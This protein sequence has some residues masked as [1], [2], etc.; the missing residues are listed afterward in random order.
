GRIYTDLLICETKRY[1]STY[2]FS[3]SA[4]LAATAFTPKTIT[5]PR[6]NTSPFPWVLHSHL[7]WRGCAT[8]KPE[9]TRACQNSVLPT[10]CLPILLSRKITTSP[11]G[12]SSIR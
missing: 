12:C 7:I 4:R 6:I 2:W 9:T 3:Y 8:E 11:P 1:Y 10:A 5:V